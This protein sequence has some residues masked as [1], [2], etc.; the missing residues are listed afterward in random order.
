LEPFNPLLTQIRDECS[1]KDGLCAFTEEVF[2]VSIYNSGKLKINSVNSASVCAGHRYLEGMTLLISPDKS[3]LKSIKKN[4]DPGKKSKT[5]QVQVEDYYPECPP[6]DSPYP[7]LLFDVK[8]I[9]DA[10]EKGKKITR[11]GFKLYYALD[12]LI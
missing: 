1:Q 7:R 8:S 6:S 10:K 9:K 2:P 3:L 4:D 5:Y 11:N 12:Y